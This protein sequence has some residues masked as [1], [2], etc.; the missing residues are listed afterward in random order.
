MSEQ[1]HQQVDFLAGQPIAQGYQVTSP[2]AAATTKASIEGLRKRVL[3]AIRD[4]GEQGATCDECE[5]VLDMTH[6]TA[7]ARVH[8]PAWAGFIVD[9]G[10]QRKTR[11]GGA[12]I[13]WLASAWPAP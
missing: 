12:A 9:S 5:I 3:G 6:Q 7:S 4:L 11:S 10:R 8:E 2:L 13:V 1:Q